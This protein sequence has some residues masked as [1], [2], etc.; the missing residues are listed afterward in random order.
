[1]G[2]GLAI[3]HTQGPSTLPATYAT[4]ARERGGQVIIAGAGMAGVLA[5]KQTPVPHACRKRGQS[6]QGF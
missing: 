4:T 6:F 2:S 3:K 1:M 5:A